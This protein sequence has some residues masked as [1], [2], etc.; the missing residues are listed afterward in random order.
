MLSHIFN[1]RTIIIEH[2][3]T[4]NFKRN[5]AYKETKLICV[6]NWKKLVLILDEYKN[7]QNPTINKEI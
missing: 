2:R 5:N 7:N 3:Q 1:V 4:N 6:P